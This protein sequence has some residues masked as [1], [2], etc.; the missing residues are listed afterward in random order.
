MSGPL[1][2]SQSAGDA[3]TSPEYQVWRVKAWPIGGFRGDPHSSAVLLGLVE[4]HRVGAVKERLFVENLYEIP[5]P[6]LNVQAQQAI[7]ARWRKAQAQIVAAQQSVANRVEQ[8]D[9]RFLEEVR[10]SLPAAIAQPRALAVSWKQMTRWGVEFAFLSQGGADLSRGRYPVVKLG[11]ILEM[12]QYGTSEKANSTRDG[13]AVIRM[14]NIIDGE[15]DFTDLKHVRLPS[16]EVQRLAMKDGDILINRTNSKELVGK[17][18]V[19]HAAGE[20]VFASYLIRLRAD[21]AVANPDYLAYVLNGPLGRRQ[22]NALS[23]Q[24]IGQAN[25]NSEELR[26]LQVPMPPVGIQDEIVG[27]VMARRADTGDVQDVVKSL[28]RQAN[29]DIETMILG[30]KTTDGS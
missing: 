11:S 6:V 22:I 19:F 26:S 14:N 3:I 24:I 13:V 9:L 18:A 10:L 25:I 12:V 20:Y 1:D 17:C 8:G 28:A 29:R 2:G 30:A 7:V 21:R 15:F 16:A 5:I 23:R 4:C 27:Q